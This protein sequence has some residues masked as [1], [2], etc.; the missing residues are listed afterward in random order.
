MSG[1]RT[2]FTTLT[3]GLLLMVRPGSIGLSVLVAACCAA[4]IGA[5]E[6]V[7]AAFPIAIAMRP[8]FALTLSVFGWFS[9]EFR[10][11]ESPFP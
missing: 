3:R 5:V 11:M 6:C 4:A 8:T 1:V 9:P 2:T 10:R 7:I